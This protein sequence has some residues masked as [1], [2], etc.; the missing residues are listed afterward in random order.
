[1]LTP[2]VVTFLLSAVL[3]GAYLQFAR[4]WQ[5]LD[6]PNDRSSHHRPTPKGGGVP[7]LLAF[8]VGSVMAFQYQLVSAVEYK[9]LLS[10]TVFLMVLGALDDVWALSVRLRFLLYGICALMVA[11]VLLREQVELISPAGITTLLLTAFAILWTLNLY[12]FM[13]GTD[14]LAA[15]QCFIACSAA[16]VLTWDS[17]GPIEYTLF[18]L[19][20]AFSHLG[21]LIWN[22]PPAKLFMGDAGSV[23]SGFLLAAL[24]VQGAVHGDLVAGCW[25]VLLAVFITDASWT[26]V[27]RIITG[28][29]FMEAHRQHAYQR[30]SRYW[31]SHRAV[32]LLLLAINVFWLFPL[33]WAIQVWPDST[34]LLVILAYIPLLMGMAKIQKLT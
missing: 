13:D 32:A 25:L 29:H 9:V 26:L 1:M 33:A 8:A 15:T 5:I 3:C 34:I 28:Q 10:S 20:L 23:P 24:A 7:L 19:L 18:C 2:L 12:N 21:F 31:D 6:K 4:R 11:A 14:G 16:A 27:W 17:G 22:W 30:L